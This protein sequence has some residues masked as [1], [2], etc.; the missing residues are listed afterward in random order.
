MSYSEYKCFQLA[1]DSGI[2]FVTINYPPI[3][4]LDDVLS[5]EFDNLSRDLEAD[6][7]VRVVVVQSA[8]PDFFIAHSGLG[9]VGAASKTVSCT[10]SFRLTQLIG[11]R[12][13]SP[14]WMTLKWD[15]P[16][17]L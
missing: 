13:R 5:Q 2:A 10:R 14:P 6:E 12:F 4:L 9:R 16:S 1:F 3:N 7:S 11:E 15:H 17:G 8:L